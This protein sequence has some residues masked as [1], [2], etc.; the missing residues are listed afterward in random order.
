MLSKFTQNSI[1][2]PDFIGTHK[3][4]LILVCNI[5]VTK[6]LDFLHFLLILTVTLS[7]KIVLI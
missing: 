6:V 5:N 7:A 1:I 3:L 2:Y 4:T